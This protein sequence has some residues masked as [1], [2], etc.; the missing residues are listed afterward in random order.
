MRNHTPIKRSIVLTLAILLV[1]SLFA[2]HASAADDR[3]GTGE[4]G[5]FT[6][7]K[8]FGSDLELGNS[9]DAAHVPGNSLLLGFR[10][11]YNLT[12]RLGLEGEMKYA[13]SK[14]ESTGN[15]AGVLGWRVN[16]L[17]HLMKG[18]FRPFA[19][20]GY[21][22]ETLVDEQPG[23]QA[24]TDGAAHMGLGAKYD[25]TE[26]IGLR[27]D[28]RYLNT[29][30]TRDL[31]EN[32]WEFHVGAGVG[33]G[34]DNDPDGDGIKGVH[35]RC[36]NR[37]EDKDGFLDADGCP[38]EDNDNDGIPDDVAQCHN[39]PETK[40]GVM[41]DDGCPDADADSDGV[42]DSRDKCPDTAE[43]KDGFQDDDGCPDKDNDGD[44]ISDSADKCPNKAEDMDGWMD[45]DGCPEKDAD[46][47]LD[48]VADS[49]DKCPN[50]AETKNG[51]KDADGCPD[52]IPSKITRTFKGALRGIQFENNSANIKSK[53]YKTL[54]KAVAVLKEFSSVK[55]LV[56]GHTDNRGARDYNVELSRSRAESVK[57]YLVEQGIDGSRLEIAGHGPDQPIANN[58]SSSGR[59]KN[60]RIEFKLQ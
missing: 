1:A 30:G 54:D 19:L 4:L 46:A 22:G 9:V 8:V 3:A 41:D 14:F 23:V 25:I 7:G 48:G 42:D 10:G 59:A 11:G 40:N 31:T 28:V 20:L 55:V 2:A 52:K 57:Q 29:A 34:G 44:K 56:A 21:G 32:V 13:P 39:K 37:A 38:D 35:D 12:E 50:K 58:R 47:D 51:Y 45:T 5:L 17:F 27:G 16:G 36:P 33:L 18:D 43:D 15:D 49:A 26:R 24:D 6:G 53:S 60:R